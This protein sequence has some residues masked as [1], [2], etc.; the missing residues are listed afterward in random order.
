MDRHNYQYVLQAAAAVE[1]VSQGAICY[2]LAQANRGVTTDRYE[3]IIARLEFITG[4]EM[5]FPTSRP[6]LPHVESFTAYIIRVGVA[7]YRA[8][9]N[10]PE[11]RRPGFYT[12]PADPVPA[13]PTV[14]STTSTAAADL[15]K[16][17]EARRAKRKARKSI[18][19]ADPKKRKQP[20]R[21]AKKRMRSRVW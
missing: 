17:P 6:D 19:A 9:R 4:C 14:S 13:E 1:R 10:V 15:S 21:K 5:R 3:E 20:A 7:W 18:L 12:V 2:A 8:R 16:K 11:D